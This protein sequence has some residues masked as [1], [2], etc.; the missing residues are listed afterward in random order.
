MSDANAQRWGAQIPEDT[1]DARE[2]LLDAAERCLER[3]GPAKTTLADIAAEA[4]VSRTTVYRHLG[5]RNDLF[6]AMTTRRVVRGQ[7]AVD[8]LYADHPLGERMVEMLLRGRDWVLGFDQPDLGHLLVTSPQLV[9][10]SRRSYHEWLERVA[11]KGELRSTAE[12]DDIVE[13]ILFLRAAVW[14]NTTTDREELRRML[15]QFAGPTFGL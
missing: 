3:W 13:W 5:S 12:L 2:L 14:S 11:E 4:D 1:D 6:V 7:R 9:D 10:A 15:V 8:E